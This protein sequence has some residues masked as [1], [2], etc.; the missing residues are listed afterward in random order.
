[1]SVE[2]ELCCGTVRQASLPELIEVAAAAGF[3]AITCNP[4]LYAES[5]LSDAELRAR[6][7]DA[8]VR[9]SNIDGFNSGLPGIPTGEAVEAFRDVIGCD[10]RACFTTPEEDYYRTAEALGG[11]SVNMM[12]FAGDPATPFDAIAEAVAGI[13]ERAAR[14]GLR[15]VFE[16]LPESGVGN[17][18]A[19]A[20]LVETVG[21]PNLGIMFDSRHLARSGGGMADLARHA[22][23]IAAV[24]ISDILW[25]ATDGNRLLPGEGE[26]PLKETLSIL[27]RATPGTPIGIEV[28]SMELA[29]M[30]AREA[31]Q[32][33]GDSL[34]AMLRDAGL[35]L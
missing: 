30:P 7:R 28:F 34:R 18:D 11:D 13:C 10:F 15:V 25:A 31:A 3:H 22:D 20:R 17:I 19:A 29:A 14:R 8:G 16:F 21:A 27:R 26:L 35:S 9:V 33:A 1:M 32:A 23:K 12:H 2:L 5:G 24:Q 4:G 6:L